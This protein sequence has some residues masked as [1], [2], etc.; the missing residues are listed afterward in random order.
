MISHD[1]VATSDGKG[2]TVRPLLL[3]DSVYNNPLDLRLFDE[4]GLFFTGTDKAGNPNCDL[5]R[6]KYNLALIPE[7]RNDENLIVSQLHLFWQL[8]HNKIVSIS[9]IEE[10]DLERTKRLKKTRRIVVHLFQR[11]V[12]EDYLEKLINSKIY[13]IYISENKKFFIK[14]D[15]QIKTVP[16]EFSHAA[17]RIG[18]S[19]IRPR[20]QLKINGPE[21]DLAKLMSTKNCPLPTENV[22]DWEVF[23]K[24]TQGIPFQ[25]SSAF[26]HKIVHAMKSIPC[27]VGN[28]GCMAN[29]DIV[30]RNLSR[31]N[32]EFLPYPEDIIKQWRTNRI[33]ILAKCEFQKEN[34]LIIEVGHESSPF[35]I[36]YF[37]DKKLPFWL[38]VLLEAELNENAKRLGKFASVIVAETLV[39]STDKQKTDNSIGF[40]SN[41]IPFTDCRALTMPKLIEWLN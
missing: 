32:E 23:F 27:I 8:I 1:I 40:L 39:Y 38:Y 10:P 2:R 37:T 5:I 7:I 14:N 36:D 15:T 34:Y 17:F 21:V 4:N 13:N 11:I 28:Q 33:D 29:T 25:S 16:V 30:E 20:Y 24:N 19:M 41:E 18:H 6:D 3:L 31:G 35:D 26:D 22:I 9:L 12:I